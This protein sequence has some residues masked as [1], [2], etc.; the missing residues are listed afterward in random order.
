[1][2][3]DNAAVRYNSIEQYIKDHNFDLDDFLFTK[4]ISNGKDSKYEIPYSFMRGR[5]KLIVGLLWNI[6]TGGAVRF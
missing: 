5:F 4:F 6:Q 3:Q 1:M 2:S